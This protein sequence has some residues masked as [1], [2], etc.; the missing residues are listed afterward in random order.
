MHNRLLEQL[1]L[2]DVAELP[3]S[4]HRRLFLDPPYMNL[5]IGPSD[6]GP[7]APTTLCNTMAAY[8]ANGARLRWLLTPPTGFGSM[9]ALA[10]A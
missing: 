2:N 5:T 6:E 1:P 8:K 9:A 3:A 4:D 10:V 7:R